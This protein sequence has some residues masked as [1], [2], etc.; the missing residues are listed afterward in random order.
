MEEGGISRVLHA[1]LWLTVLVIAFFMQVIPFLLVLTMLNL[2]VGITSGAAL[3]I[4]PAVAFGMLSFACWIATRRTK[5]LLPPPLRH[6]QVFISP[7]GDQ[8]GDM[9]ANSVHA[10]LLPVFKKW[11]R[12]H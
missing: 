7:I 9:Q 1:G 5:N 12:H 2:A 10:R 8:K 6:Q 3:I 11:R 4:I